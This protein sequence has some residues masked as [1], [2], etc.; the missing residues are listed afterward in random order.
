[1]SDASKANP[2]DS[3]VS[4]AAAERGT[5]RSDLNTKATAATTGNAGLAE[6]NAAKRALLRKP[7]Y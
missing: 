2:T 3:D 1:M 5:V 7:R 4:D 6:G